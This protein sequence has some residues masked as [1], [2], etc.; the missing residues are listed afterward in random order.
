MKFGLPWT[1]RKRKQ[2]VE[3]HDLLKLIIGQK[4]TGVSVDSEYKEWQLHFEDFVVFVE[5]PF[6]SPIVE[7][8][9]WV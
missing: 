5:S 2:V 9:P 3:V 4:L 6:P 1:K 8:I 7:R